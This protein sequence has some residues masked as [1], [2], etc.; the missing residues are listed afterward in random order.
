MRQ[1]EFDEAEQC[2]RRALR[3][4][5]KEGDTVSRVL[6]SQGLAVCL[7]WLGKVNE[8]AE[9]QSAVVTTCRKLGSL[10]LLAE[11]LND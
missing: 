9:L 11:A 6:A 2:L 8:A 4:A 7:E 1:G 10:R 5:E 3:E